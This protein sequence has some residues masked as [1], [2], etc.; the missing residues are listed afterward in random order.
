MLLLREVSRPAHYRSCS[1]VRIIMT[2]LGL[3]VFATR[4]Y[5]M[6]A[7]LAYRVGSWRYGNWL[8]QFAGTWEKVILFRC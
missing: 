8:S 5:L 7:Q 3:A 2:A 6:A 1:R 4:T